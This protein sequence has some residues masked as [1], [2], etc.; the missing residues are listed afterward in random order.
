MHKQ[1]SSRLAIEIIFLLA[2]IVGW[3]TVIKS[4]MPDAVYLGGKT[5]ANDKYTA[6][7]N[8]PCKIHAYRGETKIHG[9]Y[10]NSGS[11]WLLVISDEDIQNLPNYDGT[12]TFK[13]KNKT[14]KLVDVTPAM[15]KKLIKTSEKNPQIIKITGFAT[16]CKGVPLASIEYKDGIFRPYLNI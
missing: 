2:L 12:E 16:R 9:W 8:T 6:K 7:I 11:D 15:E 13:T 1:I 4:D 5:V 10:V 3:V 14:I